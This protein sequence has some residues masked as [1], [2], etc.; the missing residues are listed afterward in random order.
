MLCCE[1]ITEERSA[2]FSTSPILMIPPPPL[3]PPVC[4][5]SLKAAIKK[6]LGIK[7]KVGKFATS[8]TLKKKQH[9]M[10]N[11]ACVL[12][13]TVTEEPNFLKFALYY[14]IGLMTTCAFM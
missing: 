9:L 12:E 11:A 14:T 1:E 10:E 13:K 8:H 3:P 5:R 4:N 2:R 6:K 7:K